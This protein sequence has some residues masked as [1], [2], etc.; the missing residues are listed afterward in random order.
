M[1]TWK[2]DANQISWIEV[3]P[4]HDPEKWIP[5]DKRKAF[6]RRSCSN[7]KM[8]RDDDSKKS[9]RALARRDSRLRAAIDDKRWTR[10]SFKRNDSFCDRS[11]FRTRRRSNAISTI[12][13]SSRT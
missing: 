2:S 7:K 9:H 5:R 13:T 1:A 3:F 8:E 12:G 11:P 10:R 4:E 6:A